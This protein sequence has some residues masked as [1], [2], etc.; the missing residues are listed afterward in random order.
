LNRANGWIK[1]CV[2]NK[3]TETLI[4]NKIITAEANGKHRYT[5]YEILEMYYN[6][7]QLNQ[8]N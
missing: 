8:F 5:T 1:S 3:V 2:A 7:N 6:F 4:Q